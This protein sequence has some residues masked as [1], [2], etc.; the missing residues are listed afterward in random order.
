MKQNFNLGI[1]QIMPSIFCEPMCNATKA[2]YVRT[3]PQVMQIRNAP[4]GMF[5]SNFLA[6]KAQFVVAGTIRRVAGLASPLLRASFIGLAAGR[7]V[8]PAQEAGAPRTAL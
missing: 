4:R 3:V 8:L 6:C 5:A 1:L 2:A 7:A